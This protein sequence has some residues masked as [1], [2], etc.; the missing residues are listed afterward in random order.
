M[1]TT[2]DRLQGEGQTGVWDRNVL[3]LGCDDGCTTMNII[4]GIKK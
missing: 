4:K 1:L 2:G 3:K